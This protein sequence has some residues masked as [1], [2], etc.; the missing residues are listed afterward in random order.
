MAYFQQYTNTK[1][2]L[3][4]IVTDGNHVHPFRAILKDIDADETVSVIFGSLATCYDKAT[5][6]VG[7]EN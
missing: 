6:F 1:D 2:G 3:T 7:E 4:A 5:Q